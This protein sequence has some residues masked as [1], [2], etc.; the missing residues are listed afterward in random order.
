MTLADILADLVG[1]S[2]ERRRFAADQLARL[3]HDDLAGAVGPLLKTLE[4]DLDSA[5]RNAAAWALV[6]ASPLSVAWLP[7]LFLAL[8]SEHA[9]VRAWVCTLLGN[10]ARDD[11]RVRP[12]LEVVANTDPDA[13][14]QWR[15]QTALRELG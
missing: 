3:E 15:A 11:A 6:K 14:V 10:S 2:A 8:Q 13:E 9:D 5:T 12:M 4:N 1:A 7:H